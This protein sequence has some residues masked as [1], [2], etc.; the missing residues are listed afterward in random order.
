MDNKK[1]KILGIIAIIVVV[2]AIAGAICSSIVKQKKYEASVAQHVESMVGLSGKAAA[3]FG[4]PC[5]LLEYTTDPASK[6]NHTVYV[7]LDGF[8][9]LTP[10]E[11]NDF[12]WYLLRY[13]EAYNLYSHEYESDHIGGALIIKDG[14]DEFT[15]TDYAMYKNG[16]KVA[17]TEFNAYDESGNEK[18]SNSSSKKEKCYW[19]NGTGSVK[20]NYGGSD[21]EAL[22]DGHEASWYGQCGSC[23]GTGYSD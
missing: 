4:L 8:G 13:D 16:D 22:I 20:Y 23:G 15:F 3:E 19:C 12:Y 17:S 1:K 6:Y 14:S 11:M 18:K 7:E 5:E 2:G 9:N 10:A 21:L